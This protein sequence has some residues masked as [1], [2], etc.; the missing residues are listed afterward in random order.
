MRA[1]DDS[2]CWAGDW[3][4]PD[5][6]QAIWAQ[7]AVARTVSALPE[8]HPLRL[9]DAKGTSG[10]VMTWCAIPTS[11]K[12]GFGVLTQL[13]PEPDIDSG[14]ASPQLVSVDDLWTLGGAGLFGRGD[15]LSM[16]A[17]AMPRETA[18]AIAD[19]TAR[20][21]PP[22]TARPYEEPLPGVRRW[23]GSL[24]QMPH[25][26]VPPVAILPRVGRGV[27]DPG[28]EWSTESIDFATRHSVH[29]KDV[30]MAAD[31]LAPHVTALLLDHL[32]DHAAVT[33]YGDALH[34]W[35]KY[36]ET[37]RHVPDQVARTVDVAARLVRAFPSFVL[38]A[39]PNHAEQVE[40]RLAARAAEA[41]AYRAARDARLRA[42]SGGHWT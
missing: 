24:A 22:V 27:D 6:R 18:D 35:W 39:Y 23:V 42:R 33:I 26:W 12:T 10:R 3:S 19:V 1:P 8:L 28:T 36:D 34:I 29:A 11:T 40:D 30:R 7:S 25:A 31:L 5:S 15:L 41:A 4:A 32:P 16:L 13:S 21:S 37:S 38:A 20:P 9:G 2:P 17:T 14:Y